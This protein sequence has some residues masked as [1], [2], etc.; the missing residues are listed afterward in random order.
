[1]HESPLKLGNREWN[2]LA[3]NLDLYT[4][5]RENPNYVIIQIRLLGGILKAAVDSPYR[6]KLS[7]VLSPLPLAFR[8][9]SRRDSKA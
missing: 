1:M 4:T 8:M 2:F 3:L 7:E 6:D 5:V 9:F